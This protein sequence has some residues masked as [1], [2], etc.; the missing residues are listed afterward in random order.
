M[1]F[2]DVILS[3]KWY[4]FGQHNSGIVGYDRSFFVLS[5]SITYAKTYGVYIFPHTHN[6]VPDHRL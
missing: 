1:Y 2:G 4:L 5:D 6:A 3:D